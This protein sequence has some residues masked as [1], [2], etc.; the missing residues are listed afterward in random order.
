VTSWSKIVDAL[1]ANR[2]PQIDTPSAAGWRK[3]IRQQ[4]AKERQR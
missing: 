3:V 4:E 1:N 2:I